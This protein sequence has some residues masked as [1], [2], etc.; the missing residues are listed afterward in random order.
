MNGS[1]RKNKMED[2][3]PPLDLS[4]STLTNWL[5]KLVSSYSITTENREAKRLT[6]NRKK[7]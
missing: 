7:K 1:R 4:S 3:G 5:Q 6:K 2:S